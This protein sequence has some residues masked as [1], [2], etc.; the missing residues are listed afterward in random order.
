MRVLLF[1][2]RELSLPPAEAA[3]IKAAASSALLLFS[4]FF[5]VINSPI[6]LKVWCTTPWSLGQRAGKL[7]DRHYV[8]QSFLFSVN[9]CLC[10]PSIS[11][12]S[13]MLALPVISVLYQIKED[14]FYFDLCEGIFFIY[15]YFVSWLVKFFCKYWHNH[16]I[17]LLIL[18]MW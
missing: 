4:F 1:E 13:L 8:L 15:E 7:I 3:N 17:S 16:N 11:Q 12:L 18:F 6:T 10:Y 9:S 5:F 2:L 14:C